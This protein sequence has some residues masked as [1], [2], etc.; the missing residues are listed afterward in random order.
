MWMELW[1]HQI[2]KTKTVCTAGV[3]RGRPDNY[4]NQRKI[5]VWRSISSYFENNITIHISKNVPKIKKN[6]KL[7]K[8]ARPSRYMLSFPIQ[9][10]LKVK[11]LLKISLPILGDNQCVSSEI[12]HNWWWRIGMDARWTNDWKMTSSNLK[13]FAVW[14][15]L[16][17]MNRGEKTWKESFAKHNSDPGR[18]SG[19]K[20]SEMSVWKNK[21]KHKMWKKHEQAFHQ[22]RRH[23]WQRVQILTNKGNVNRMSYRDTSVSQIPARG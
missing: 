19:I 13:A 12:P 18:M 4:N 14:K 11:N 8:M 21:T 3:L 7:D 2:G 17:K 20:N 10:N 16:V 5:S 22:K 9:L 23:R 15:M 6:R 1:E